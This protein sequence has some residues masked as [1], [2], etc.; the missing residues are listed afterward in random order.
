MF[1]NKPKKLI[2]RNGKITRYGKKLI[3]YEYFKQNKRI[4]SKFDV[5]NS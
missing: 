3:K 5:K 2:I 4:E 1:K